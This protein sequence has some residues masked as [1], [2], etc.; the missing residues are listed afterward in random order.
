MITEV[1]IMYRGKASKKIP[2]LLLAAVMV[3]GFFPAGVFADD[4]VTVAATP[5]KVLGEVFE[6]NGNSVTTDYFPLLKMGY[7]GSGGYISIPYRANGDGSYTF[8]VPENVGYVELV[9]NGDTNLD[10]KLSNAD[11]TKMKAFLQETADLSLLQV[12]AGDADMNGKISNADSTK[13]KAVLK[14]TASFDSEVSKKLFVFSAL[15]HMKNYTAEYSVGAGEDAVYETSL[16]IPAHYRD[17]DVVTLQNYGFAGLEGLASVT[18]PETV[19]A[20]GDYAFYGCTSLTELSISANV[21]YIGGGAFEDCENLTDVYFDGTEDEWET[22]VG[23]NDSIGLEPGSVVHCRESQRPD[24][25]ERMDDQEVYDSVLPEY[26][27]LIARA[28]EAAD[29]NERYALYAKAEAALLD[30]AVMMPTTASG[31]GYVIS[32]LAYRTTPYVNWG[33]DDSKV[34]GAV[35]SSELIS[36]EEREELKALWESAARG[37]GT[38][39]P[40]AY[41]T[42]RGHSIVR[43]YRSTASMGLTTLDPMATG[44]AS[45]TDILTNL[46][47]GLLEYDNLGNLDP[48]IAQS[49]TRSEDGRTYIFELREGVWWYDSEGQ[50]YAELTADDFVAGMQHILDMQASMSFL[51]N[52]FVKGAAEYMYGDVSFSEVGC[53]AIGRYTLKITLTSPASYFPTMLSYSCFLPMCRS[54]YESMG[55]AFGD[56]Y[57]Q[58]LESG[59]YRYG[60]CYDPSTMVY[61][62]AYVLTRSDNEEISMTKNNGYYDP[63][64]V[65][66]DTVS[67][68]VYD[69]SDPMYLYS[70]VMGGNCVGM[71][72]SPANGTVELA[73]QDGIFDSHAYISEATATTYLGGLNLNRG[74]FALEGGGCASG[75]DEDAKID[76]QLAILNKNFR[77]ALLHAFCKGDYNAA[78]KGELLRYS[79]LRNTYTPPEFVRLSEDVTV[80]GVSFAAGT[81]YGDMVSY[82]L[83]ERGENIDVR[84]GVDGWYDPDAARNYLALAMEELGSDVNFPVVIDVVVYGP[85]SSMVAQADAVKASIEGVLGTDAVTVNLVTA[86]SASE[87]YQCGYQAYSGAGVNQDFF[88]GS[89]WGPDYGDPYSY[90]NS[91]LGHGMGQMT[92]LL[93]LF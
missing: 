92:T 15:R 61:N 47:D 46:F 39:D 67:F 2:A 6:V 63:D 58:A 32:R 5:E 20:I 13:L 36:N 59:N 56:E 69:G 33:S 26:E 89:G 76:Y 53:E 64:S 51:L 83:S 66:I 1:K 7:M 50:P 87:Y 10:G 62:G 49:W 27:E 17:G 44:R 84:D 19:F 52:G 74:A 12:F 71:G 80:D 31:G 68:T 43:E 48:A 14:E 42:G 8:T 29:D 72:L 30:S 88:Y 25:Y 85:S 23:D 34:K 70:E 60:D 91:F 55:G 18:I 86:Q 16:T 4:S 57:W 21:E 3:F 11:A 28:L 40:K 37:Q 45:D 22:L 78:G 93:G 9:I 75:K 65:N 81:P 41:L 38:Y 77:K 73:V 54:F 90:L 24:H 82:Y 79:A 35:I